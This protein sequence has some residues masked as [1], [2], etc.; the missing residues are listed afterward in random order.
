MCDIAM[1]Y[2]LGEILR[3]EEISSN[4]IAI[5]LVTSIVGGIVVAYLMKFR[6]GQIR[7]QIEELDSQ[8]AYLEKLSKGNI[9]LLRSSLILLF[10]LLFLFSVGAISLILNSAFPLGPWVTLILYCT[11]IWAFAVAAALCVYQA[12]S[13]FYSS[14]LVSARARLKKKRER[15][16]SRI[17]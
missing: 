14:D 8:E 12:K 2:E 4:A 3:M 15:L 11:A 7:K 13:I 9:K 6:E 16:Q 17:T 5:S 10:I 1:L